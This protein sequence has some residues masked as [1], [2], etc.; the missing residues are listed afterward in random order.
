MTKSNFFSIQSSIR[1]AI[2][3]LLLVYEDKEEYKL[4]LQEFVL[5]LSAHTQ[6]VLWVNT[7]LDKKNA[8][9]CLEEV[10]CPDKIRDCSAPACTI[11]KVEEV[12][13]VI[14]SE[15]KKRRPIGYKNSNWVQDQFLVLRNKEGK[16]MLVEPCAQTHNAHLAEQLQDKKLIQKVISAQH[17]KKE[18]WFNLD[19][20]NILTDK[21]FIMIGGDPYYKMLNFFK[22]HFP[23]SDPKEL[24]SQHLNEI[25]NG[26]IS[27]KKAQEKRVIFVGNRDTSVCDKK[28]NANSKNNYTYESTLGVYNPHLWIQTN[29]KIEN[30]PSKFIHLD[31][32]LSLTGEQHKNKPVVILA[33]PVA[34]HPINAV[35]ANTLECLLTSIAIRLE[36]E[37]G[38]KVLRNPVPLINNDPRFR[39]FYVGFYNNC[40]VERISSTKK[41][42]WLPIYGF[43]KWEADLAVFDQMNQQIWR[44]LGYCVKNLET[45]FHT[46]SSK[47]GSIHCLSKE[48]S[49]CSK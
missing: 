15:P 2:Q 23:E 13:C 47:R 36:N 9:A 35:E 19:G 20:G 14:L 7:K 30:L 31:M 11:P 1:G 49:R 12:K 21:K 18:C 34:L 43:R 8:I 40:L 10:L 27:P 42:V 33:K 3:Q 38:F 45:N 26:G 28:A 22:N 48:L 17:I 37:E 29:T 24:M 4:L 39:S 44:R 46:Y 41:T 16:I 5:K 32:L 6:I 25:L